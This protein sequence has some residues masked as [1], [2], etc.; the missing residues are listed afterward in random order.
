MSDYIGNELELFADAINWKNYWSGRLRPFVQGNVLDVGAG[1]GSNIA[2]LDNAQ[3]THWHA[4]EP[5]EKLASQ[6]VADSTFDV[7]VQ[8]GTLA[9]VTD[10][11]FDTVLYIDVLEHIEDDKGELARAAE[12][13]SPDGHLVVLAPAHNFLFSPFD[14]AIGHFRR[15]DRQMLQAITPASL[16]MVDTYY[17]DSVGMLASSANRFLL[18]QSKPGLSQIRFWDRVMVPC[19]RMLD[20]VTAYH[21]GKTIVSIMK[22]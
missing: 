15:Y 1:I 9:D 20:V 10:R 14:R 16:T 7:A 17:L 12:L 21:L 19:S 13:L 11:Q 5:D 2:M 6:I 22:K 3:I 4:L 18:R 8:T